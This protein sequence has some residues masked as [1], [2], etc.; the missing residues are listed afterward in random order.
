MVHRSSLMGITLLALANITPIQSHASYNCLFDSIH[1]TEGDSSVFLSK[2]YVTG[3]ASVP[4]VNIDINMK[5]AEVDNHNTTTPAASGHGSEPYW[6]YEGSHG[7]SHWSDEFQGCKQVRGVLQS[8]IN[9]NTTFLGPREVEVSYQTI[10]DVTLLNNG[11]TIQLNATGRK[12]LTLKGWNTTYTL[13]QFHFHSPSEHHINSRYYPLEVHFVHTSVPDPSLGANAAPLLAVQG[14]LFDFTDKNEDSPFLEQFIDNIPDAGK[15]S[16]IRQIDFSDI[17][18]AVKKDEAY[19]YRGSLTTPPCTAP[20]GPIT[21]SISPNT[22]P[23]SIRQYHKLITKMPFNARPTQDIGI[24][25]ESDVPVFIKNLASNTCL[26]SSG[27]QGSFILSSAEAC[28]SSTWAVEPVLRNRGVVRVR[29]LESKNGCLSVGDKN[30]ALKLEACVKDGAPAKDV[31]TPG[32]QLFRFSPGNVTT[33]DG[34][35]GYVFTWWGNGSAEDTKRCL[36]SSWARWFN[37]HPAPPPSAPRGGGG[38]GAV[39]FG[40]VQNRGKIGVGGGT[41]SRDVSPLRVGG[42]GM[43]VAPMEIVP[44]E[45]VLG[46]SNGRVSPKGKSVATATITTTATTAVKRSIDSVSKADKARADKK[47]M[48][49]RI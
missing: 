38:R 36:S 28:K 41:K 25:R 9:L 14:V 8:P 44:N 15:T 31:R 40:A 37:P 1:P 29:D 48:L 27:K 10:K 42:D 3:T 16:V 30:G 49:R 7:P 6:D 11:H 5:S 2:R 12:N 47:R 39:P 20:G 22:L 34:E 46:M 23:I 13:T 21:F 32:S 35:A 24:D 43:G 45:Q 18:K 19:T 17:L 26:Q 33:D 4:R